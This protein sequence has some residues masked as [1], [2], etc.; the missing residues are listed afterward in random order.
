MNIVLLSVL[1]LF[2]ILVNFFDF[3]YTESIVLTEKN[4][5]LIVDQTL[6]PGQ[7]KYINI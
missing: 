6:L 2:N 5:L 4:E 7:L 1:I 3:M